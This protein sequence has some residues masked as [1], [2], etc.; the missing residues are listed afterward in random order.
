M[1]GAERC[2]SYMLQQG[3]QYFIGTVISA[4]AILGE[5]GSPQCLYNR[6]PVSLG[7]AGSS[8]SK[9]RLL[10]G[11]ACYVSTESNILIFKP[12]ADLTRQL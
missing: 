1:Q 12:E 5:S 7:K 3:T 9:E 4:R 8:T 2:S 6:F 10:M 11:S